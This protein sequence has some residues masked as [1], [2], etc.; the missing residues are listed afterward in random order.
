MKPK[1]FVNFIFCVCCLIIFVATTSFSAQTSQD[2]LSQKSFKVLYKLYK[3]YKNTNPDKAVVYAERLYQISI[4][5]NNIKNIAKALYYRA[6]IQKNLGKNDSALVYINKSLVIS[7]QISN[8]SLLLQNSNLKGIIFSNRGNY[9]EAI[10]HYLEAKS[11][12]ERLGNLKDIL[13]MSRNIGTIKKQT[14]DYIGALEVFS[15]NLIKIKEFRT[16]EF[17][18][19]KALNHFNMADTYLRMEDYTQ[20]EVYTDSALQVVSQERFLD[21]YKPVYTNK[22]IVNFQQKKYKSAITICNELILE[23]KDEKDLL[24]PYLYLAKSHFKLQEYNKA[25]KFFENIKSI[26][27]KYNITFP[28]Q[29]E[30]YLHLV[31]CYMNENNNEEAKIN[32]DL[33]EAF[34]KKK[35]ALNAQVNRKIY[36][37]FDIAN[38]KNEL[39]FLNNENNKQKT[40]LTILYGLSALMLMVFSV[41]FW[42]K[43]LRNSRRFK[44]LLETIKDLEESQKQPKI[45][46]KKPTKDV[47][48]DNVEQILKSLEKF[49]NDELFLNTQ[50]NLVYVAKKLKTNTSY[51][52]NVINTHKG[53]P[54]K[55]YL[56]ELR[57]NASLIHL[58]NEKRLR[59]YTIKALAKEFGFKRYETFSR[60][61]K[62]QTGIYPSVYIKSLKKEK[63]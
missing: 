10:K 15:K 32:I 18:R 21:L 12:A 59:L 51:L 52:S 8:D 56:T 41:V 16:K 7:N 48:P 61:F 11:I 47:T 1:G 55:S 14:E 5:E 17:D 26:V 33:L 40:K 45:L 62:L 57:I 53:K 23:N 60:A 46:H 35:E 13:I 29:E 54:F 3:T 30:V 2:S 50:C 34:D 36:K 43:Q 6:Y 44:S 37:E 42:T 4:K 9:K 28:E 49:E 58:K 25:I 39:E 63:L 38:I 24:T 22:V 27:N 20:A 31:R 19:E